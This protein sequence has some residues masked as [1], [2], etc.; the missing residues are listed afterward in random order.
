MFV[1]ATGGISRGVGALKPPAAAFEYG[2]R[3][4]RMMGDCNSV[5][6][7]FWVVSVTELREP[8]LL[9]KTPPMLAIELVFDTVRV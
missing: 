8:R 6:I 7:A 1:K 5:E 9:S 3:P 4:V 2:K